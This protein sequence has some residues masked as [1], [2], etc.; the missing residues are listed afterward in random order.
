MKSPAEKPDAAG[1][2]GGG[3]V[4]HAVPRWPMRLAVAVY[5]LF[6]AYLLVLAPCQRLG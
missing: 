6:V 4:E 5:A 2:A 3:T 1:G